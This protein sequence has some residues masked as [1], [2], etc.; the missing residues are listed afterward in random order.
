MNSP[1]YLYDLSVKELLGITKLIILYLKMTYVDWGWQSLKGGKLVK[2]ISNKIRN[3]TK[4][5]FNS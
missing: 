2:S 1:G 5:R 4:L 3:A